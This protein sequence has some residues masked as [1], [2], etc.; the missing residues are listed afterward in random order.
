MNAAHKGLIPK[1]RSARAARVVTNARLSEMEMQTWHSAPTTMCRQPEVLVRLS[2]CTS[3]R[4]PPVCH[5]LK[6]D[7]SGT[8]SRY[9][10]KMDCIF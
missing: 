4:K 8:V 5:M 3:L 10:Q 2:L 7:I 6:A 9:F 1:N